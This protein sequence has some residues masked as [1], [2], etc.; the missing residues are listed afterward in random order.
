MSLR[1]VYDIFEEVKKRGV[2]YLGAA[3]KQ[4]IDIMPDCLFCR[5]IKGEIKSQPVYEDEE[6]FAFKDINPQAPVHVLIIP[7]K[8]I[9][10][11]TALQKNDAELIGK[12]YLAAGEIAKKFSVSRDGFRVV[13]NSGTDAGETVNHLHF[14]LLGGRKLT[15]PPG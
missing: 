1:T 11:L 10:G 9:A 7:K 4:E 13:V 5:I 15:W 2:G 12:I 6:I 8:H 3:K 14:H